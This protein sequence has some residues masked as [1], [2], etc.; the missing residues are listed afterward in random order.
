MFKELGKNRKGVIHRFF[1]ENVKF[2]T[3]FVKTNLDKVFCSQ[4]RKVG[5]KAVGSTMWSTAA[6]KGDELS[7]I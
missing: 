2:E 4:S 3:L 7:K 6:L 5:F 1:E